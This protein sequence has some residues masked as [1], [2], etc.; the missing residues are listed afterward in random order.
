LGFGRDQ[1]Q[2]REFRAVKEGPHV[3]RVLTRGPSS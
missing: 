2:Q 3:V 1:I